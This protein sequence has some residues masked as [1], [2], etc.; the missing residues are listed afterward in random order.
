MNTEIKKQIDIT[1]DEIGKLKEM[2][3]KDL[4]REDILAR[5][6]YEAAKWCRALA[7]M[8]VELISLYNIHKLM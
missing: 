5:D 2:F 6:V 7:A 1:S 8:K 4:R 3:I